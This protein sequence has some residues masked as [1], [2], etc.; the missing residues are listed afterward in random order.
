MLKTSKLQQKTTNSKSGFTIIELMLTMSFVAVLLI[1]IAI[2]T[3]NIVSI[4]QKGMTLKAVNSVGRGLIDELTSAI[5][6]APSVDTTSLC[7][8]LAP[9]NVEGCINDQAFK[10]VYQSVQ[11]SDGEQLGGIFCTGNY[12]YLWNTFYSETSGQSSGR[13]KL[14]YRDLSNN[15]QEISDFRLIRIEDKTHRACSSVVNSNYE[16][17]LSQTDIID[18]QTLAHSSESAPLWNRIS[19]PKSD[20]LNEFDLDLTLYE[21]TIFHLSQDSVTLRSYLSGTFILATLRGNVDIMRSGDYCSVNTTNAGGED[22]GSHDLGSE[23]N[24]CAIN[25]FNFAA[26]TAGI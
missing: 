23:F 24:Y 26:R 5:N 8:S 9:N 6:L 21:L 16:S 14:V 19:E 4:Y 18:V 1:T 25:K 20:F 11:N 13:L 12:S 17:T 22:S 15:K 3:T 10:Y 2:V 7:N